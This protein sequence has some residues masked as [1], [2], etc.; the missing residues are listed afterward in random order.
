[1][2]FVASVLA[3]SLWSNFG[4][5]VTFTLRTMFAVLTALFAM[6]SVRPG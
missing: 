3:G 1:M 5:P 2:L 6:R 4:A